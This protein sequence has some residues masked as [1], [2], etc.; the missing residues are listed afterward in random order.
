LQNLLHWAEALLIIV[1]R[2]PTRNQI[3]EKKTDTRSFAPPEKAFA[4][5]IEGS[6]TT[7]HVEG[8]DTNGQRLEQGLGVLTLCDVCSVLGLLMFRHAYPRCF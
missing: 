3:V 7:L 2:Q 4:F 5:W 6:D 8:T 1:E